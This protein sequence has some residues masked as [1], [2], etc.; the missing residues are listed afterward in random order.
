MDVGFK[1]LDINNVA[2]SLE[3]I[4]NFMNAEKTEEDK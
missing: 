2:P 3:E 4:M 1:S